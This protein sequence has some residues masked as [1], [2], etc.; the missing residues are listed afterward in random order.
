M[1]QEGF[2]LLVK[3]LK[4]VNAVVTEL[5]ETIRARAFTL[6]EPYLAGEKE[7]ASNGKTR[8]SVERKPDAGPESF[9]GKLETSKP[10]DNALAIAAYLYSR[11][12]SE[13]TLDEVRALA[14]D[15]GLTIP[16]RVDMTFGSA[17]R[18]GKKLFNNLGSGRFRLTVH[19]ERA[20]QETYAVRKGTEAREREAVS[21]E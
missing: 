18:K 16:S 2:K 12:G 4:E 10:S 15:V 5:D 7:T 1:D 6:F 14:N 20:L 21:P 8:R 3:R 13:I 19:G 17:Y 11:Y 9:F